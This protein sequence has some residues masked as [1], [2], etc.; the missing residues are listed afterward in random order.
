MTRVANYNHLP[1]NGTF[2]MVTRNN[3]GEV[4]HTGLPGHFGNPFKLTNHTRTNSLRHFKNYF[5]QRLI[6]DPLWRAH[7]IRARNTTLVCWCAPEPCHGDIL[8]SWLNNLP[9][10]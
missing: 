8:A 10:E 3:Q 9:K 5:A 1:D 6:H 7:L 2:T 4:G